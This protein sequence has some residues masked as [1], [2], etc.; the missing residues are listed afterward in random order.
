MNRTCAPGAIPPEIMRWLQQPDARPV[1]VLPIVVL[2]ALKVAPIRQRG[3][4]SAGRR[5]RRVVRRS[6]SS[7]DPGGGEPHHLAEARRA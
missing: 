4:C 5:G 2:D 7:D 3:R 1:R 6:S